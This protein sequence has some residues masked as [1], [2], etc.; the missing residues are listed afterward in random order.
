MIEFYIRRARSWR[1]RIRR[2]SW[3]V[4]RHPRGAAMIGIAVGWV[5]WSTISTTAAHAAG[6]AGEVTLPWLPPTS[7]T[8]SAGVPLSRYAILPLDRGDLLSFDKTWIASIIDPLWSVNIAALGWVLWT[9]QWMLD[10]EWIGWLAA[11]LNDIAV[12]VERFLSQVNWIPFALMLAGGIAGLVMA[13]GRYAKGA[14]DLAV[15]VMCSVLAVGI[16]ANPVAALTGDT[17]AL[18][19]AQNWGANL[20]ASVVADSTDQQIPTGDPTAEQASTLISTTITG[21][22]VDIF[23]RR[24]AQV[25]AFGHELT[26]ECDNTFTEQAAAAST[27]DSGATSVRDA[28]SACDPAAAEYVTHPNFGQVFTTFSIM[29]GSGVLL[30]LALGFALVLILAVFYSLFQAM[31]LMGA[32]YAAVAPGVARGALWKSLIGMYVGA[33]S[34]GMSVVIL[35]A[36]LKILTGLLTAVAAAGL[37]IAA[38]T[39]IINLVVIALLIT[40]F[41]A[42]HKAKKA[43]ETLAARLAGLGF[44]SASQARPNPVLRSGMRTA[45]QYVA[46]KLTSPRRPEPSSDSWAAWWYA[47]RRSQSTPVTAPVDAGSYE[48]TTKRGPGTAPKMIGGAISAATTVGKLTAGAA[49]GGASTMALEATKLAGKTVLQRYVTTPDHL[50]TVLERKT[51]GSGRRVS[52]FGRHIVVGSDGTGTI[53]PPPARQRSGPYTVISLPPR[54]QLADSPVR[55]ALEQASRPSNS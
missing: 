48:A 3:W 51:A 20:S 31:K 4:R 28:I 55:R 42:R 53:A 52:P 35:A 30:L 44:G 10:F 23:V 32:V 36:Y 25:I 43:G 7:L 26:G 39:Y 17:G 54:R 47:R 50:P 38:Q 5:I 2:M 1:Y 37:N 9:F 12:L 40:L 16:L 33:I 18:S 49:T 34:V 6:A 46:R 15:S 8:D 22:L 11:P 13:S 21:E 14:A 27:I 29:G 24:P 19:W 45:E 41:V